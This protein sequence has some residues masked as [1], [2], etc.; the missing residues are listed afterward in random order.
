MVPLLDKATYSKEGLLT[1]M[2]FNYILHSSNVES[3]VYLK[4][5]NYVSY[6]QAPSFPS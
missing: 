1:L 5:L 2:Y 3:G 4:L 6:R